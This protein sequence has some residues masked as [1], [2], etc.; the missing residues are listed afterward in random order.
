[1]QINGN[2]SSEAAKTTNEG[3]PNGAARGT[4]ELDEK[5]SDALASAKPTTTTGSSGPDPDQATTT[6]LVK[7]VDKPSTW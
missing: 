3:R 2:L 1:M 5:W 7:W 4:S 6:G